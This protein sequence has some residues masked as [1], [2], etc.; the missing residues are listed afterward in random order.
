MAEGGTTLIS[1]Q[2]CG[3]QSSHGA[4]EAA[5]CGSS[6]ERLD[7]QRVQATPRV[8]LSPVLAHDRFDECT[9]LGRCA[10]GGGPARRNE[11]GEPGNDTDDH[12]PADRLDDA[13]TTE[14]ERPEYRQC[15]RTRDEQ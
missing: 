8:A 13:D 14:P 5:R 2:A 4:K 12:R 10:A 1:D 11:P 6:G 3:K 7:R 15:G 9:R